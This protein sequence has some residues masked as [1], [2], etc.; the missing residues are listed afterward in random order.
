MRAWGWVGGLIGS[1]WLTGA[2]G[3]QTGGFDT[4]VRV[5]VAEVRGGPSDIFPVTGRLQQ[6]QPVHVVGEKDGFWEITPPTGSSS[7]VMDTA[8]R[9]VEPPARGKIVHAYVLADG[10]PIFL[11]SADSQKPLPIKLA[12]TLQRG[13]IVRVLGE[14]VMD[15][16]AEWWRIQPTP[17]EVRYVAREALN[18][19]Q[20]STVVAASPGTAI[21]TP[22]TGAAA[23]NPLWAQAEQAERAGDLN[24]ADLLYGQL[25][26]Q[27]AQPGGDHDLA[28]R[29]YNRIDQLSKRRAQ[30]AAWPA[31]QPAPGVLVNG[32]GR[33]TPVAPASPPPVAAPAS[34]AAAGTVASGPGWLRRSGVQI[35]G[36]PAFVLEN[37]GGQLRY[38]LLAQPGLNLELFLNRPVEVFGPMVQRS[39]L[40]GG[41]YVSVNRLHLLR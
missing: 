38:Y 36:R 12:Q 4:T 34:T 23:V 3:A 15:D 28:I 20:S 37:N 32:G 11:G 30:V 14:K 5:P 27:M 26:R 24:K 21:Q 22:P 35:D 17:A 31:R 10:A 33:P 16:A 7:W 29:C 41:G 25:A 9:L 2:L 6:R 8:L 40:A 1:L 19:P 39:E 18:P 13:T